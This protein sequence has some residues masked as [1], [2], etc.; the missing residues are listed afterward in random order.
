VVSSPQSA[1]AFLFQGELDTNLD[2]LIDQLGDSAYWGPS[3]TWG[4]PS[5]A[6]AEAERELRGVITLNNLRQ[7][8][9]FGRLE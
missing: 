7:L 3:W 8:H 2:Y 5:E 6:W 1:F 4:A 9:A